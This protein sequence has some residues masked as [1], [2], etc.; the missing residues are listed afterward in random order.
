[1]EEGNVKLAGSHPVFPPLSLFQLSDQLGA[2]QFSNAIPLAGNYTV[3]PEKDDN[4]LNGVT[5][6]D[7]A[8]ISKHILGIENLNSPYKIIAAI[9]VGLII[10]FFLFRFGLRRYNEAIIDRA[11]RSRRR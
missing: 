8:L 6:L 11:R 9:I 7:L 10:I 2:Y 4:P 5:T 3:T 1:V